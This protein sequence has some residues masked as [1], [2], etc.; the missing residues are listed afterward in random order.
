MD[1]QIKFEMTVSTISTK[2]SP[3]IECFLKAVNIQEGLL[4]LT[5]EEICCYLLGFLTVR[6]AILK[7]KCMPYVLC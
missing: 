1:E 5:K 2:A 4:L 6:V 7:E 3:A